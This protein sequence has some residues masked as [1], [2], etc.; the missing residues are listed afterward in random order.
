[1][2][3]DRAIVAALHF[4]SVRHES[5]FTTQAAL[6][7]PCQSPMHRAASSSVSPGD[8]PSGWGEFQARAGCLGRPNAMPRLLSGTLPWANREPQSYRREAGT[9]QQQRL[10]IPQPDR[11]PFTNAAPCAGKLVSQSSRVQMLHGSP[12]ASLAGH[13]RTP[14]Q[15][16][17]AMC[18][19]ISAIR[20]PQASRSS[21]PRSGSSQKPTLSAT[22]TFPSAIQV[23]CASRRTAGP[24]AT[25]GAGMGRD[26]AICGIT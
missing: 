12:L 14:L 5:R 23:H 8:P 13:A 18:R 10:V 3:V 9:S 7:D 17:F 16:A 6:G 20:I 2:H 11:R 22:C 15:C 26:F 25:P 4:D 21:M 1:M 24:C 19:T